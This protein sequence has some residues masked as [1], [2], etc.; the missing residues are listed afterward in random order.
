LFSNTSLPEE[1]STL[2][3]ASSPIAR[4]NSGLAVSSVTPSPRKGNGDGDQ[5]IDEDLFVNE[6][7]PS[8][9]TVPKMHLTWTNWLGYPAHTGLMSPSIHLSAR[10]TKKR[11]YL[12]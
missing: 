3:E 11:R 2:E 8:S 6:R 12:T 7:K 1:Q 10:N 9:M 4:K 5:F